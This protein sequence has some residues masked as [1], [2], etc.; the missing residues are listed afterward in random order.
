MNSEMGAG[1]RALE[2][3]EYG[4]NQSTCGWACST[5]RIKERQCKL[6][7]FKYEVTLKTEMK[8]GV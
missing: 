2:E 8:M 6:K 5:C 4:I 7:N 3:Y 1:Q